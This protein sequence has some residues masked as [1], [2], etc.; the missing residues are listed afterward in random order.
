[1]GLH[2]DWS[3]ELVWTVPAVMETSVGSRS[4]SCSGGVRL[5]RIRP[6]REPA[7]SKLQ[8]LAAPSA[9]SSTSGRF[10]MLWLLPTDVTAACR[11]SNHSAASLG[12]T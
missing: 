6:S 1:M 10:A 5:D 3:D 7:A 2:G 9:A 11:Q 4:S 12:S 8:D